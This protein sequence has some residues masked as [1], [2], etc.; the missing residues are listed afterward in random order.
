MPSK[1]LMEDGDYLLLEDGGKILLNHQAIGTQLP[2]Q[3]V[4]TMQ[5]SVVYLGQTEKIFVHMPLGT[6]QFTF[7]SGVG[8]PTIK[9]LKFGTSTF[10][11]VTPAWNEIGSGWYTISLTNTMKNTFGPMMVRTII[12]TVPDVMDTNTLIIVGS[13]DEDLSGNNARIRHIQRR[14]I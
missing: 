6:D 10:T 4:P 3:Y 7:V 13:N 12:T 8:T 2:Y 14:M 11:T 1:L 5:Q 9:L